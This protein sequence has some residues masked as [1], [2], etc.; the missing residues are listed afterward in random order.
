MA[1]ILALLLSIWA[2]ADQGAGPLAM[3]HASSS[4][5]EEEAVSGS[6]AASPGG[7]ANTPER[8]ETG[9]AS[10]PPF[11]ARRAACRPAAGADAAPA[12][13]A[14]AAARR[15]PPGVAGD[16][17]RR[18]VGRRRRARHAGPVRHGWARRPG[19]RRQQHL[20]QLL[21]R[22]G[23]AVRG[24]Q[25][26]DVRP[27]RIHLR[28]DRGGRDRLPPL[29]PAGAPPAPLHPLCSPIRSPLCSPPLHRLHPLCTRWLRR[30]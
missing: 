12:A 27:H 17:R 6:A 28:P 24:R 3:I 10:R 2:G 26:G 1:T 22:G 16:Q 14:V 8:P 7:R 18:A 30:S 9:T 19:P 21:R 4:N 5:P 23:H 15:S 20:L 13:R 11:G 29:Q 25:R